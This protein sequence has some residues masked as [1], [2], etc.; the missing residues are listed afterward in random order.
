MRIELARDQTAVV[1]YG[2]LLS[3]LSA[4]RT[5]GRAYDGPFER[6]HV[7]GWRR[8]WDIAMP[9]QTFYYRENGEAVYPRRI[10]Y[11]NVRPDP[12]TQLNAVVFVVGPGELE[13]LHKREWIY[14]ARVVTGD[15]KGVTV[16]GGDAI[17]YVAKPEY[18]VRDVRDPREAA[19][20]ASYLR[21]VQDGLERAD[22]A[23]RAEYLRTTDP[24]PEHLVV[25]DEKAQGPGPK[26]QGST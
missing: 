23:F 18:I 12:A 17:M 3:R 4:E 9:N 2:S 16:E 8:S 6:C 26:A 20:R 22:A 15:L 25:D 19:V 11:L 1:G 14:D 13:E 5:L 7:A 21:I 10:L 24:V